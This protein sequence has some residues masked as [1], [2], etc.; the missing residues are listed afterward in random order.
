LGETYGQ[1]ESKEK[2]K[3]KK[4]KLANLFDRPFFGRSWQVTA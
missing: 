1:E 4:D 3:V 2:E